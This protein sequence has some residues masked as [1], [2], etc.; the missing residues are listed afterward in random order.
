[1]AIRFAAKPEPSP[2]KPSDWKRN[3][4]WRAANPDAYRAYMR[5]YMRKKRKANP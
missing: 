1:M 2:N 5:E 3:A 4:K